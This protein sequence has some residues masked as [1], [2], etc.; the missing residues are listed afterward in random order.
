ME[1]VRRSVRALA[2]EA[3][4]V[5]TGIAGSV[6]LL[7]ARRKKDYAA[8]PSQGWRDVDSLMPRRWAA[9]L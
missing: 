6:K 5:E 4:L 3:L 2:Q 1:R 7:S 9:A 8:G